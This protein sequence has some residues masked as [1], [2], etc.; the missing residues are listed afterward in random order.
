MEKQDKILTAFFQPYR[1]QEALNKGAFKGISTA[2]L[3]HYMSPQGR[4]QLLAEIL[5]GNY[6]IERPH[7]ARI[8]KD[9]PGEFRTVFVN[10]D[11][12]RIFLSI[13]NDLLFDLCPDMV[14]SSCTS[15][16]KGI[17]CSKIV[18][19]A[20]RMIEELSG[21]EHRVIGWKSDLSKYF[22]SVPLRYIDMTF[23]RVEE[24]HGKSVIIDIVREYYHNDHYYDSE[25]RQEAEKY[26]SLK[27]GCAVASWLADVMLY[28][29]DEQLSSLNGYYIRYSDDTLFI[30][31]DYEK[32][33]Q[34]MRSELEQ[35]QMSL[36]PKK[37]EYLTNSR[38]F[39]FLG[40]AIRGKDI[41]LAANRIHTFTDEVKARTIS[42]IRQGIKPD[43]ARRS[44]QSWLYRGDGTHSWATG[45]LTTINVPSD[46][47]ALNSFV[48]DCL[49]AVQVGKQVK[50]S[51][52]GGL[53]WERS[54]KQGCISRGKGRR[55][56]TLRSK[57]E[58]RIAGFFSLN[59]M[60]NALLYNRSLYDC[61]VREIH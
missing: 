40:Y 43:T 37:V 23:N 13:V 48:L 22:D 36:N 57:T 47:N 53:G 56:R 51:D 14:H 29:I 28:H 46:I 45:V 11:R 8:P 30:G 60:R 17:G 19:K 1:W 34:I 50:A 44:V 24:K 54:G 27:Q 58:G 7:T 10:S 32:A 20:S 52:I 21:S 33:M 31:P 15:Y 41:S 42:K 35:M 61:M 55:V 4:E 5:T 59:C 12:D 49:R 18:T 6:H 38:W 16:Q 2:I 39:K 3:R 25:L 26:Q 9:T